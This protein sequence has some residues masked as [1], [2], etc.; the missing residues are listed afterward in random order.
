MGQRQ[1]RLKE[2]VLSK[3]K[4]PNFECSTEHL[5]DHMW[6]SASQMFQQTLAFG[7]FLNP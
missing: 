3:Y 4:D 6:A 1:D 2:I 5:V 7:I